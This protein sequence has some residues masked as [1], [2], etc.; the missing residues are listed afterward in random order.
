MSA[1]GMAFLGYWG[2]H[3]PTP[4]SARD[5]V[6]V[7]L[8]FLSFMALGATIWIATTPVADDA[9]ERIAPARRSFAVGLV[10]MWIGI[11]AAIVP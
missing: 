6:V 3:E 5:I 9:G 7:C 10:L 1:M 8:A 11:I 4:W 2:V